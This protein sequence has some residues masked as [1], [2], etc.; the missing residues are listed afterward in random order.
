MKKITVW[1]LLLGLIAA[2]VTAAD[3]NDGSNS[4]HD[5]N[6]VKYIPKN[7]AV[8]I[9]YEHAGVKADEVAICKAKIDKENSGPVYEVEFIVGNTEYE[10]DID[11]VTGAVVGMEADQAQGPQGPYNGF[12]GVD[13]ARSIVLDHAGI[14]PNAKIEY[15]KTKLDR[16][17]GLIVYEIDFFYNDKKYEYELDAITGKVLEAK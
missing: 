15:M 10:F 12:I 7:K 3:I 2:S 5:A 4:K 16:D 1:I 11:A 8:R 13:K 17:D 6:Y 9:A 14:K